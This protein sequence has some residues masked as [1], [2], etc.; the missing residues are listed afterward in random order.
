MTTHLSGPALRVAQI[1]QLKSQNFDVLVIGGG[2]TGAGI[3]RDAALRGFKTALVEKQDFA[4]GT[5]G[6]SARLI[7][8]GLRYVESFQFSVVYQACAE[9]GVLSHIAPHQVSPVP[10]VIPLAGGLS[11]RLKV[12]LALGIYDA[13]ALYRNF[14]LNEYLTRQQVAQAE[15]DITLRE[16]RSAM[17]YWERAM[18]DARM[19]L[20]TILSASEQG[21]LALNH[22]EVIGFLKLQGQVVGVTVRDQVSGDEF[23]IKASYVINAGGPWNDVIRNLDQA[24]LTPS[25]RPNKGIH[26]IVPYTRLPIKGVMNFRAVRSKRMLYTV[27]W[28]HTTFIGT[29]DTDYHDDLDAVY[30]EQDEVAWLLDSVNNA[31]IDVNLTQADVISTYAGLRP[32]V[33]AQSSTGYRATREHHISVSPSGLISIAGGKF[34]THRAM[35]RDV[36]D[37]VAAQLKTGQPCRTAQL[38]LDSELATLRAVKS[39]IEKVRAASADLD[40]DVAQ[41][42]VATYGSRSLSLLA[43]IGQAKTLGRRIVDG[44]PYLSAEILYA[45]NDER[46]CTLNDVMIRRTRLMHE[47]PQ[48][49]LDVAEAIAAEMKPLLG[50]TDAQVAQQLTAYRNQV[51]LTRRFDPNW[52]GN[53]HD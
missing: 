46:A 43:T 45:V 53:K 19:T 44:L 52:T 15:P 13:L 50:W 22:A 5:S 48:Q 8:G 17:R 40:E 41:H 29:T 38:P 36:V 20:S 18:D 2:I 11:N 28:R 32:L 47:L 35:A 23:E 25:V 9:R 42:L 27:P 1:D 6:N 4:G 24:G 10:F 31:F 33:E 49:G 21:A 51:A 7:H 12:Q 26:V 16:P 30:A 34:T 39:L 3:A 37:L 14:H